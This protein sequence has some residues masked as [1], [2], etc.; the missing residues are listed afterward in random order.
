MSHCVRYSILDSHY[1][2]KNK[3]KNKNKKPGSLFCQPICRSPTHKDILPILL[4]SGCKIGNIILIMSCSIFRILIQYTEQLKPKQ[5]L[6][7]K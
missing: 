4:N 6:L 1:K 5:Y 3:N 7:K 2:N